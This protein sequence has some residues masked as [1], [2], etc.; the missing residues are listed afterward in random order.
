ML[1]YPWMRKSC[2]ILFWIA[3][4]QA[5][6][7]IIGNSIILTGPGAMLS[8]LAG[9]IPDPDFWKTI[10]SSFGRITFGFLLSFL[11]G[12][13]LGSL[14]YRFS[15]L[16]EILEPVVNLMKSIPVASFIIL[17]L[18]WIGS[19]NLA[20]LVSFLIVFPILYIN[21]AAGLESTDLKLL[22]MARVFKIP[23]I[24][25]I[26]YIYRPALVPYLISASKVTIGMS[27]KSGIA[28]EVI[29]VPASSIGEKLYLSKI[30]L[31]T[32]GLLAW[33]FVIIVVSVGFE[34]LFLWLLGKLGG[35]MV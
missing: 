21:T 10:L 26:R 19:K 32:A 27:W 15:L 13:A 11:L 12:L 25:R 4:W 8:S 28:A 17:A 14:S 3:L 7:I 34:K 1:H 30:Y 22:E 2:I 6:S 35:R 5:A 20:V 18:I 9:Q 23:L 33:T 16:K 24:K 29:G 31:D